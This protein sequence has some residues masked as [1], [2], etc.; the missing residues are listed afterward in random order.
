MIDKW[1]EPIFG[2]IRQAWHKFMGAKNVVDNLG[3]DVQ[4]LKRIPDNV[5][6]QAERA[7]KQ[8]ADLK[9]K[10]KGAADAAKGAA[11][12]M[13]GMHAQAQGAAAQAQGMAAQAQGYMGGPAP[14][15]AP[16]GAP[17]GMMP[18]PPGMMPPGMM[19]PPGAPGMMA[20]PPGRPPMAG[21]PPQPFGPM[22]GPMTPM[23]AAPMGGAPFPQGPPGGPGVRTMALMAGGNTGAAIG[24][25]VPVK[26]PL[27]GELI[28]LKPVSVIGKDPTC[29]V[30]FNDPFMSGR[31]ATIRAT[32]GLF[33][34]EDH[35]TN[36]TFVNDRKVQRHDLVDNDF[37]KIGQT[38]VKF[39]AL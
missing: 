24:W 25:L 7:K 2:P 19:P 37:V 38:L 16:P 3:G 9:K 34:L 29:D 5:K 35:S 17:P 21:M 26:G 39:K 36:G 33:V 32:N 12:K 10:A 14:Q 27:R 6:N 20:G 8:A 11:D 18:P 28:T 30:V 15:G 31:H 4:R 13:K 23:G 22:G 1:L